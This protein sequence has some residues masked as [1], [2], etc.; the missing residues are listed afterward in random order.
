[1]RVS[2]KKLVPEAIIPT[3][4]KVGDAGLDLTAIS[5]DRSSGLYVEYGTGLAVE[6]PD[7]FVGLLFPRSSN[8]KMSLLLANSCGIIDSGY[9]GEI[10]MR[11]KEIPGRGSEYQYGDRIGQ[12][13]ILPFP[14]VVLEEVEEL[15][16]S[17][18]GNGGFGSTNK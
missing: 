2:I 7:C 12:L 8:S 13:L 18:R 16:D 5:I 10:K 17:E 6:I 4:A 9:R 14:F 3:Y 15:R 11:F 1:M